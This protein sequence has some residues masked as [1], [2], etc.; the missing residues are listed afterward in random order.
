MEEEWR[1]VEENPK[2]KV[3][4]LGNVMGPKG[5]LKP[6]VN[7]TYGHLAINWR[8]PNSICIKRYV[9]TLVLLV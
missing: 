5:I 3:S 6:T 7:N 4:N 1:V 8:G 9:H 2:Y